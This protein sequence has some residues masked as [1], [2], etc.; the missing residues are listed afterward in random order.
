MDQLGSQA[1]YILGGSMGGNIT[2]DLIGKYPQDF[3]GAMPV[4]GVVG[5]WSQEIGYLVDI[6]AAYNYFTRDTAYALPGDTDLAKNALP[7]LSQ[8]IFTPI[9]GLLQF[10]QFKRLTRPVFQLFAAANADPKGPEA[11]IID[12]ILALAHTDVFIESDRFRDPASIAVPLL[13]VTYGMDNVV[14]TFHGQLYD[15]TGKVY[16]TPY[17][18]EQENAALNAGIQR[19]HGT[20]AAMNE[21]AAWTALLGKSRIKVLSIHNAIDPLV[22]NHLNESQLR[23]AMHDAG[24]NEL[25]VQRTVPAKRQ[26]L[27]PFSNMQGYAHCGFTPAQMSQ[28]WDDLRTWVQTGKRPQS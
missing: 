4:C 3:V 10:M 5:N 15:N 28:G 16:R 22:P 18:S 1:T 19:L 11:R 21:A 13:T 9:G 24:Q 20:P 2:M 25:L 14:D 7:T 6:R 8:G 12:N 27:E 26:P 23:E 17:L